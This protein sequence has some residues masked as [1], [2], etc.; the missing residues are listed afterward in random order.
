MRDV[1]SWT[2]ITFVFWTIKTAFRK[3]D[4][5]K[6]SCTRK[7]DLIICFLNAFEKKNQQKAEGGSDNVPHMYWASGDNNA[8]HQREVK[9]EA[10]EGKQG[11]EE[12]KHA[13]GRRAKMHDNWEEN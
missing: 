4:S 9:A 6:L 10:E 7:Y 12:R 8:T 5:V 3:F 1:K 13:E 11:L 2:I